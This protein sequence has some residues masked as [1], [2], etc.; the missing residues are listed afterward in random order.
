MDNRE[1]FLKITNEKIWFNESIFI[2]IDKTDIPYKNLKFNSYREIYWKV[3]MKS[4]NVET[5]ILQVSISNYFY[6]DFS[7]FI[8]QK[9]KKEIKGIVFEKFDWLQLEQL[10]SIYKRSEFNDQLINS[11]DGE[12]AIKRDLGNL[13]NY[14]IQSFEENFSVDINDT[15]FLLGYVKFTKHI[16]KL[17]KPIEFKI[18]N[19]DILPEFDNIKYWFS[20]KLKT[21]KIKVKAIFKNEDEFEATSEEIRRINSDLIEGVKL[22]RILEITQRHRPQEI[23]KALFTSDDIFLLDD[24]NDL[25]GNVFSQSENDILDF[26]IEKSNVRNKRELTYLSGKKHSIKY[27]IRF[28]NHPNFGF[29]FLVEGELNNHFIWELL[30]TNATYIWTIEKERTTIDLQY[31]RIEMTINTILNI[32]REPYKRAF[33]NKTV[34]TDLVFNVVNHKDKESDF[35]DGFPRWKQRINDLLT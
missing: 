26:L 24:K 28:T 4:F 14:Q 23:D 25:Q 17:N 30:N 33:K 5:G 6:S 22:Q 12:I 35:I 11:N 15:S 31:K 1:I 9:P 29:I 20:K 18:Y 3:E 19:D 32:K 8:Q 34:D 27:R 2:T 7:T 10:L 21:K 13:A 16:K